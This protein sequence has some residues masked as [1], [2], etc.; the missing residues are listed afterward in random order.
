MV[1]PAQREQDV[2]FTATQLLRDAIAGLE[3]DCSP[4]SV[5]KYAELKYT[6]HRQ[7]ALH[8]TGRL[9]AIEALKRPCK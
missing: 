8:R 6:H 2:L 1:T 4:H 3:D 9:R 7:A 5:P